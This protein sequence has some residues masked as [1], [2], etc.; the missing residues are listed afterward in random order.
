MAWSSCT[1]RRCNGLFALVMDCNMDIAMHEL[2]VLDVDS[3]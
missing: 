3:M 1:R 2:C